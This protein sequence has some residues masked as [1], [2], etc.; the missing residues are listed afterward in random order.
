MRTVHTFFRW[1]L[2]LLVAALAVVALAACGGSPPAQMTDIPSYPNATALKP[3]ENQ[4]ADT[5]A[6]NVQMAGQMG[7]KLDQ[8]I[9]TLPGNTSWKDV[10]DFY[11]SK[12]SAAGWQNSNL[13][14]PDND[15]MQMAVW[16]RGGQSLT[17]ARMSEPTGGDTFL[18]FSLASQ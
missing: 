5:L 16:T 8:Q 11:S 6:K 14:I 18:L 9:F 12:L 4:I 2:A 3:G 10:K 7:Q 17:V 13:P 15:M 1:S